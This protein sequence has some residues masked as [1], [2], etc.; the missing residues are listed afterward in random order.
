MRPIRQR[1]SEASLST[2]SEAPLHKQGVK[3]AQSNRHQ[4]EH[5]KP[6]ELTSL[7]T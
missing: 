3:R 2:D 1:C 4:L 5:C 6:A 7:A